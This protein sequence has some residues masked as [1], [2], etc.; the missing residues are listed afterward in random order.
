VARVQADHERL[1]SLRARVFPTSVV[2]GRRFDAKTARREG[3]RLTA[4]YRKQVK[5][6][7]KSRRR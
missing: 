2:A 1:T 3:L 4:G 6:T 5:R 7:R